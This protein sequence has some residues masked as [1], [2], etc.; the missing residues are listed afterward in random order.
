MDRRIELQTLLEGILGSRY[1]Y[2]QPPPTL[3]MTYPCIRYSGAGIDANHA[4]NKVYKYT[5]R[6][7]GVII[8]YNPDST[9]PTDLLTSFE[10]CSLG[11]PYTADGL[12]HFPF[13]LYY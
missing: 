13:T 8:E 6:Y 4:N 1:V 3:M 7:D 11:T 10:M 9:L 12:Y 2:F 5:K